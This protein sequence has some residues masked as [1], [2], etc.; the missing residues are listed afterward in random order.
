MYSSYIKKSKLYSG[1]SN[2]YISM[3]CYSRNVL[4]TGL[5]VLVD[6]ISSQLQNLANDGNEKFERGFHLYAIY[7]AAVVLLIIIG[8]LCIFLVFMNAA[9]KVCII[10]YLK[11]YIGSWRRTWIRIYLLRSVVKFTCTKLTYMFYTNGL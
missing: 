1:L 3:S 8:S 7:L 6:I 2:R 5:K 4:F 11:K 10:T 9:Y